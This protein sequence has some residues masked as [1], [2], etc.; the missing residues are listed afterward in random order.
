MYLYTVSKPGTEI[1]SAP[2]QLKPLSWFLVVFS[3]LV[4]LFLFA[5]DN[6]IVANVQP[7]IIDTLGEIEKLPWISVAFAMGAIA[8]DLPWGQA[9]GHFD[10]KA[11][12]LASVIIFEVGSAVCGAAPTFNALIIGRTICGIG[13]IGIYLGVMNMVS[14]LTSETQRPIYLGIVGL[15]WGIGTILGPIIGGAFADSSA[16]WRCR[17]PG[18]HILT[19]VQS[20]D[21]IGTILSAGA[22]CS[23][24]FSL[25][26][27]SP[28][29][30]LFPVSLIR[31]WE[32]NILF[33][34][35]ASAQVLVM[36][37]IYFLPLIF[38]FAHNDSALESGVHLL[39]FVLVLVFAVMLNGAAMA[40]LG[41]YMAWY[42]LGNVLALVGSAL[43]YTID[44]STSQARISGYSVI[45]AFGTGLY[46]QA[47]FPVAQVKAPASQL[48]QAV[49]FIGVGQ[50][51]GIALALTLSNSIFLNRATNG[52]A[53][54][55]P[56]RATGEI[57]QAITGVRASSFAELTA[58][59]SERVLRVIIGSIDDV[60]VL[61]VTAAALSV[62]LAGF[63]KR[64]RLFGPSL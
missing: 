16:S 15:T 14:A 13:G 4:A 43:L 54:I 9:Y 58:E 55:L 46:S 33:A 45:T 41:F 57:Q 25:F 37:P 5:L 61:M 1:A 18:I 30:R 35:T 62:V 36:V 44:L 29:N 7:N 60:F 53:G 40:Q 63:L 22:I 23:L 20:L 31:S 17:S 59:Q 8:T 21:I 39:P 32:M 2:Q 11:L 27:T 64:E 42:L 26:V 56:G 24:A 6:T 34:Q 47:S 3:L 12:F 10:N 19:R 38:Q 50:V 28:E 51:G 49:S 48:F 52:I